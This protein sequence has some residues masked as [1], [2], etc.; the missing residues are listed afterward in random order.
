MDGQSKYQS[1]DDIYFAAKKPEDV[2]SVLLEK[3]ASFFNV[4][5]ANALLEKLN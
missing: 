2:A 1:P 3:S 4:L 5:R